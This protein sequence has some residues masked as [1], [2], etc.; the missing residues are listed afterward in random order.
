MRNLT[1][2][3]VSPPSL[4]VA[5]P[6][7]GSALSSRW[8]E[9][10]VRGALRAM[11]GRACAFCQSCLGT[12]GLPGDVDHF[13]PSSKYRWLAYR[14]ENYFLT[15]HICNQRFKNDR[16]P[17]VEGMPAATN[18]AEIGDEARLYL[19]PVVDDIVHLVRIDFGKLDYPFRDRQPTAGGLDARR[20][21][22]T[23]LDFELNTDQAYRR[24]RMARLSKARIKIAAA[25]ENRIADAEVEDLRRDACRWRPF[26]EMVRAMVDAYQSCYPSD[27]RLWPTPTE[28]CVW[29]IQDI[30][31]ELPTDDPS[32]SLTKLQ[33]N[34]RDEVLWSL[35]TLLSSPP[36][37]VD[38]EVV[39]MEIEKTGML[40]DIIA[41]A[42]RLASTS[43]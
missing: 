36:C 8:R 6:A 25:I 35:A 41:K 12:R 17:I 33:K 18:D 20:V 26:G 23:I 10:D 21:A 27:L 32:T 28:E 22:R 31:A 7:V 29:W 38:A 24:E 9:P 11:Q 19:D 13:R 37:G 3:V 30:V 16:F 2:P 1:R 15:C 39:R 4:R 42:T 5:A 14:F 43:S 40:A 34:Q